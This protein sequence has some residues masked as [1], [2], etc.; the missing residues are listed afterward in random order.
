M[1]ISDA[2]AQNMKDAQVSQ[3]ILLNNLRLTA[4]KHGNNHLPLTARFMI[5]AAN[6]IE[7]QQKIIDLALEHLGIDASPA[8]FNEFR[9][10]IA[11]I[12]H[13]LWLK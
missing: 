10:R 11:S 2:D 1:T 7:R 9:D 13:G 3:A 4:S 12:L 8:R 6:E 5:E